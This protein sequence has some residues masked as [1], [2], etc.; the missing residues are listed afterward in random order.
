MVPF[1]LAKMK[2]ADAPFPPL[3]TETGKDEMFVLATWPVGPTAPTPPGG[4]RILPLVPAGAAF[5]TVLAAV[6]A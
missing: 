6:T 1:K 2:L 3:T 5:V 4:M